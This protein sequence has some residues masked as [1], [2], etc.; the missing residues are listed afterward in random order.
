MTKVELAAIEALLVTR[1]DAARWHEYDAL[2]AYEAEVLNRDIPALIAEVRAALALEAG[3]LQQVLS[4]PGISQGEPFV[5]RLSDAAAELR[6]RLDEGEIYLGT[7]QTCTVPVRILEGV[8]AEVERL[9]GR[10][11]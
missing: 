5:V 7:E 1:E 11:T 9:R 6:A 3:T 8:L 4:E 10:P 2:L